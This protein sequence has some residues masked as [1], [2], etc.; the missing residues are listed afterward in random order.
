MSQ[1]TAIGKLNMQN[2]LP[3]KELLFCFLCVGVVAISGALF[4]P[5]E[6]YVALNKPF[7]TPPNLVF[8]IAWT[9]LYLMIAI[10]GAYIFAGTSSLL[11]QLW[12]MQLV[13]NGLWSWLFFGQHWVLAGMLDIV[14]LLVTIA[15]LV[16]RSFA[17][18]TVAA[19]LLVPYLAWVAY[20]STLNLGIYVLNPH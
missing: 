14:L 18:I 12:V 7:W 19:W 20:A 15:W 10:A 8:P 1:K 2:K 3:L 9:L 13:F 11:K 4:K 5:G 6:W 16:W 17:S